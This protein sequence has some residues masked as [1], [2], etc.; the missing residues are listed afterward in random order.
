MS[1]AGDDDAG[2]GTAEAPYRTLTRAL[3]DA[4]EPGAWIVL[5]VGAYSA[6]GGERF[7]LD[8]PAGVRVSG[9][10]SGSCSLEGP[11]GGALFRATS[12]DDAANLAVLAGLTLRGAKIGL[13]LRGRAVALNDVT[14]SGLEIGVRVDLASEPSSLRGDGF[15]AVECGTGIHAA[16]TSE[17]VLA[18]DGA[19][20][21]RCGHGILLEAAAGENP[22]TF[23]GTG[24]DHRVALRRVTFLGCSGAGVHRRGA[25]SEN[26]GAPYRFEECLFQGNDVGI[27]FE[28]PTADSPIEVRRSRFL[29]NSGFGIMAAGLD[30]D[31]GARS[32][33]ADNEFRWNGVG[34][35][36]VNT[37]VT[38]D[39]RRNRVTDSVGNG[40]FLANFVNRPTATVQLAS[41]L[42]ADNGG[43][44][45]YCLADSQLL[46]VQVLHSTIANNGYAG[47]LRKHRHSGKSNLSIRGCIVAGNRIGDLHKIEASEVFNSLIEDGGGG[48]ENG[49]L[50]GPPGF[51][52]AALRDYSLDRGSPCLNRGAEDA[53]L[54]ELDLLG[55]PRRVGPPDLGAIERA[56]QG[57]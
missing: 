35:H 30:G 2:T 33:I 45:V 15:R 38:Y 1:N 20:F 55:N 17:L 40:L 18:L 19:S 49:N 41:N 37:Q 56:A 4:Q 34:L 39:V 13:E 26:R 10:G 54:G 3:A 21:E 6:A 43:S 9:S 48:T 29:S 8:L 50:E 25:E 44:G 46:D 47:V 53:P 42:I 23:E 22:D 31:P 51:R 36:L 57:S 32:T 24:V 11:G 27:H 28:R 5:A 14:C 12:S 7:P 52:D 16:G